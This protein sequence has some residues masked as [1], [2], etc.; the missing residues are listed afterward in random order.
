[1]VAR[2]SQGV[3]DAVAPRRMSARLPI[4]G[5]SC[6]RVA[7][8]LSGRAATGI[9][10]SHMSRRR[11]SPFHFPMVAP[12]PEI[13]TAEERRTQ[14]AFDAAPR[15]GGARARG[16]EYK[17]DANTSGLYSDPLALGPRPAPPAGRV[18]SR[19]LRVPRDLRDPC[20]KTSPCPP[21]L[22]GECFFVIFV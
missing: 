17:P 5:S 3:A 19:S 1:R 9:L 10:L 4:M 13:S 8:A 14:R 21:F 12:V 11:S 20:V 15:S 22:R 6:Q 2:L 18:E 16:S 7:W